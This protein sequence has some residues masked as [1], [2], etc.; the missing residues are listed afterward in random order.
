M[1]RLWGL[2]AGGIVIVFVGFY[3][4]YLEYARHDWPT[5][6]ARVLSLQYLE[7][8]SRGPQADRYRLGVSYHIH[9][10]DIK[11]QM[12]STGQPRFSVGDTISVKVDPEDVQHFIFNQ[13]DSGSNI[14]KMILLGI[15][16]A[17][18][19]AFFLFRKKRS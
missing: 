14:A 8:S 17:S 3:G 4:A 11:A 1:V 2:F 15:L 19:A 5:A 7:K 12:D 13:P 10:S 18:G 16:T 9:N 6:D